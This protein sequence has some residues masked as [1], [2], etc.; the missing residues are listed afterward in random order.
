MESGPTA[1]EAQLSAG[2]GDSDMLE[3]PGEALCEECGSEQV[4]GIMGACKL[5]CSKVDA[6][7]P[8]MRKYIAKSTLEDWQRWAYRRGSGDR[9]RTAPDMRGVMKGTQ[10]ALARANM[11]AFGCP[12]CEGLTDLRVAR[13]AAKQQGR[14]RLLATDGCYGCGPNARP[15]K[16]AQVQKHK[17]Q[18]VL[19]GAKILIVQPEW[20]DKRQRCIMLS[21]QEAH[22][23]VA[24]TI[25][26]LPAHL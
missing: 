18:A 9:V 23:A 11:Q 20:A 17:A 3:R 24:R 7:H 6:P 16:L 2:E 13:Q 22:Q 4:G 21:G 25:A 26:V 5:T 12:V 8:T 15:G 14:Q 10:Q 19:S 1:A